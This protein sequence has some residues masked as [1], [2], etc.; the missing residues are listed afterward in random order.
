MDPIYDVFEAEHKA[1][2]KKLDRPDPY[3]AVYRKCTGWK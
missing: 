2:Q 1:A 3:D